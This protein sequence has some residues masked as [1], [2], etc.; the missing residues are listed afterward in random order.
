MVVAGVI[1]Y[2]V[3]LASEYGV[4]DTVTWKEGEVPKGIRMA[5]IESMGAYGDICRLF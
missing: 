2:L 4:F 3:S 1:A 5:Y